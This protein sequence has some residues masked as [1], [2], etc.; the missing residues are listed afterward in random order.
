M[1]WITLLVYI[2][3]SVTV[4]GI[5]MVAAL[6]AGLAWKTMIILTLI[7]FIVAIPLALMVG[8]KIA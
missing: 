1:N 3:M 8:K 7:G 6:T 5:I 2:M 4:A